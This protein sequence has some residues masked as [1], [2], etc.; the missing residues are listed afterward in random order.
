MLKNNPFYIL[1]IPMDAPHEM[2]AL[3]SEALTLSGSADGDE[4]L[5]MIINPEKRLAAETG[6]FP[7]ASNEEQE[8]IR[9][10]VRNSEPIMTKGLS[11]AALMNARAYNLGIN[12]QRGRS[13]DHCDTQIKMIRQLAGICADI[14]T[15]VL[16]EKINE[17]R[18]SAGSTPVSRRTVTEA[19]EQRRHELGK[20]ISMLYKA[21]GIDDISYKEFMCRLAGEVRD[22]DGRPLYLIEDI[23]AAYRAD[24][25]GELAAIEDELI[26]AADKI[27]GAG[28]RRAGT[29][30]RGRKQLIK[31][32]YSWADIAEPMMKINDILGRPYYGGL[33]VR[34]KC[35]EAV[36]SVRYDKLF[37]NH[38]AVA[39]A[40]AKELNGIFAC[41]SILAAPFEGEIA[42]YNEA[43]LKNRY[44]SAKFLK[45]LTI[46]MLGCGIFTL[47]LFLMGEATAYEHGS[48]T[49]G[50]LMV[51]GF[52]ALM[53]LLLRKVN[54]DIARYEDV[55]VTD[56]SRRK[57]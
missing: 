14:D 56:K 48:M 53:I 23:I 45:G 32:A 49:G 43:Q 7:E 19:L 40:M 24:I 1:N 30:R 22:K 41:N 15:A 26:Q 52:D 35:V 39:A 12:M 47:V 5:G 11:G 34:D 20:E 10:A 31:S 13:K 8:A 37:D 28:A 36:R 42:E 9:R 55:H 18:W 44:Y 2:A 38:D 25:A 51:A 46:F 33:Q 27:T 17:E 16:T 57:Y 3:A 21:G 29:V 6:W 54:R 4:M 50:I